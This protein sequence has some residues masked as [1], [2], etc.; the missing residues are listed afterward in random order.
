MLNELFARAKCS[1]VEYVPGWRRE[2]ACDQCLAQKVAGGELYLC[3]CKLLL[4]QAYLVCL[5]ELSWRAIRDDQN[6]NETKKIGSG[7]TLYFVYMLWYGARTVSVS[8]NNENGTK[9]KTEYR[10]RLVHG[11]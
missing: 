3:S 11:L 4:L 9:I 7:Y 10:W 8:L 2:D 1:C 5:Y 6:M